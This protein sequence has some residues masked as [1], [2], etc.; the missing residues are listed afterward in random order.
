[1]NRKIIIVISILL[2]FFGIYIVVLS[3]KEESSDKVIKKSEEIP[4]STEADENIVDTISS[5]EKLLPEA[6]LTIN[7]HY[8]GCN[9][10]VSISMQIPKEMVNMNKKNVEKEY[11]MWEVIEYTKDEVS[12]YKEFDGIC[13]EHYIVLSEEG[14]IVVYNVDEKNKKSLYCITEISTEYLPRE[15]I[16]ELEKGIEVSTK[17]SLNALLENYE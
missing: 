11:S 4:F 15:D 2:I 9:H 14:K 6:V 10:T 13:D 1:M 7:K 12:L 3:L 5:E 16:M 17:P 8:K